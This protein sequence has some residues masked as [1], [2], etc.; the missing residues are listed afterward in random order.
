MLSAV[1]YRL[2]KKGSI[3]NI[4]V[5]LILGMLFSLNVFKA[6][7]NNDKADLIVFGVLIIALGIV[8]AIIISKRLLP[9]YRN[10]PAL[11]LND[12]GIVDYINFITVDWQDIEAINFKRTRSSSMM[13]CKLK[14]ESD[15]GS[16]IFISLR[17]IEGKDRDIYDKAV[18]YF[19][20]VTAANHTD[21]LNQ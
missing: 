19:N 6:Y 18:S 12:K 10:T 15:R 17:W 1:I 13:V 20:K 3:V 8:L 11:E 5:L 14:W 9:A 7:K 2:S 16:E 21:S 4:I